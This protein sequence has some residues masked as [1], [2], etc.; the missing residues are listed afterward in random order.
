MTAGNPR[1]EP[2][3]SLQDAAAARRAGREQLSLALLDARNLSLLW[4]CAFEAAGSL[5]G[6][7]GAGR[8]PWQLIGRAAWWQEYW[9]ARHVQ[10]ARG[11]AADADAPRLASIEPMADAWF[12]AAP[13]SDLEAP[14]AA[15]LRA[16]LEQTLEQTLDLLHGAADTDAGLHVYRLALWHEDRLAETL[17]VAAQWI[18]VTPPAPVL[19]APAGFRPGPLL[20]RPPR[21]P[22]LIPART[23]QLG[24]PAG[25]LVPPNERFAHAVAVPEFEIDAQAVSWERLA[26]FAADGGYDDQSCWA[27]DGWRWLQSDK[28][29][30]RRAPRG[31]EQW[32][33]A[34]QAMR[35]GR[36]QQLPARQA[37]AHVSWYE[38]DAWCR[39]AGRRLPTEPEWEL[40]AMSAGA[41]G[42]AWG[43]VAEWVAGRSRPWAGAPAQPGAGWGPVWPDPPQR[44][45]RGASSWA[46]ARDVH[47]KRRRFRAP[48]HD[49]LFVG[50]RSCAI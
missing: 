9:I 19:E 8:P 3:F 46:A 7:V 30:Q 36:L 27:A 35:F 25:G 10:R 29:G 40:A 47:P 44:V 12:G 32:R 4:L 37:A 33:G 50:F 24:S 1:D 11:E 42:F 34:V 18:G 49:E 6:R 20:A 13:Q 16:Y 31:V 45:V 5:R 2:T 28:Q 15:S 26:E 21:A 22:L 39:W 38:A 48:D 17:A 41:R 23:M 14:S 43:D